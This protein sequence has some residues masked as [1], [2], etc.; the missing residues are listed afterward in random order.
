VYI[1]TNRPYGVLY[2]GVTNDL[3]ERI[4]AHKLRA[5][6]KFAAKYNCTL[7]VYYQTFA[8]IRD[9]IDFEKR[10]KRWTRE[11]KIALIEKSN[12]TWQELTAF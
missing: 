5:G 1:V 9:A 4:T 12:P 8:D 6:G 3:G 2:T 10:L 7:L 11:W